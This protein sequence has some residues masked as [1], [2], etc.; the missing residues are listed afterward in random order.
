MD[1]GICVSDEGGWSFSEASA[2]KIE[3]HNFFSQLRQKT[4]LGQPCFRGL[5][6]IVVGKEKLPEILLEGCRMNS[7]E[8]TGVCLLGGEKTGEAVIVE[9]RDCVVGNAS[10]VGLEAVRNVDLRA[11][12]CEFWGNGS[13]GVLLQ[14]EAKG[15]F[16]DCIISNNKCN[17]GI[18]SGSLGIFDNCRIFDAKNIGLQVSRSKAL[19]DRSRVENFSG[20]ALL[21]GG[22]AW[23]NKNQLKESKLVLRDA[24]V[25]GKVSLLVT[26]KEDADE[27]RLLVARDATF[28]GTIELEAD[29][30]AL[31][32]GCLK[33]SSL[34][35]GKHRGFVD[36]RATRRLA[37]TKERLIHSAI[38]INDT[39]LFRSLRDCKDVLRIITDF[40]A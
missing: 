37:W 39:S 33:E 31:T 7:V 34:S 24:T 22:E 17:V 21:L 18:F 36:Y 1:C 29:L 19:L 28:Q 35:A 8:G 20:P 5:C 9:L 15:H 4:S 38:R 40:A 16:R 6:V 27:R 30:V 26:A 3:N 13:G 10:M 12:Q 32:D 25:S 2:V 14:D 23:R 11:F